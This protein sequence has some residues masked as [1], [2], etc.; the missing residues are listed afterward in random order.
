MLAGCMALVA[1]DSTVMHGHR[2]LQLQLLL[3]D[4]KS[5]MA[6]HMP[7]PSANTLCFLMPVQACSDGRPGTQAGRLGLQQQVQAQQQ[8]QP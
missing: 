5:G 1:V 3:C 6:A 8:Q 2:V 4:R 7:L